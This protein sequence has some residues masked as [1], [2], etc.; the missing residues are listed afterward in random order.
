MISDGKQTRSR[1][2]LLLKLSAS[3]CFFVLPA[4]DSEAIRAELTFYL[5]LHGCTITIIKIQCDCVL[6]QIYCTR[7]QISGG[8][9]RSGYHLSSCQYCVRTA[10]II[11]FAS[12]DPTH[13]PT[14]SL[15]AG[16]L[17]MSSSLHLKRLFDG[18]EGSEGQPK[19][20]SRSSR[21]GQGANGMGTHLTELDSTAD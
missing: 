15:P 18:V 9:Y 5:L 7:K 6:S 8:Q 17:D 2:P 16:P 19:S 4:K 20:K 3:S 14:S 11:S 13:L 1:P 12:R 10:S 21:Q